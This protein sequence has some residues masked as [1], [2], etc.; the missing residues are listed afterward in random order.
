MGSLQGRTLVITGGSRG[1]GLAI[2]VRA[3]RDGA[4]VALLAKTVDPDPRLPGT[5]ST[6][7]AEVEAAG[8]TALAIPCDIRFEDQV[9][10]AIDR[11][12]ERFG[13]IDTLVNN[14]SAIFLAGTEFTPMKKFDLIHQVNVRG[15]FLCTQA[16]L[17]HL[18][19]A[20]NPHVL[21][22]APPPSLDPH[23][24]AQHLPY[25]LGK[26][27]MSFCVLGM[28]EEFREDG[29]AVN[30]LWPQTHIATAAVQNL[31]GGEESVRHSRKPAIV[32]DAA[33]AVL[34]RPARG[35]TGNFFIDEDVLRQEGV[36]DFDRYAVE[37]GVEL[38]RDLFL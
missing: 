37:P 1:I 25:S 26:Y 14:A 7:A 3:A 38:Y 28:A 9:R 12:A 33:H 11:V 30:A 36:T 13:A 31:L 4:N 22:M 10:A 34:S 35:C 8:G 15:T 18:R 27:G 6:A 21:V 5:L 20:A 29:V 24:W 19:R 2:A 32:A 23:W 16:C 17:P